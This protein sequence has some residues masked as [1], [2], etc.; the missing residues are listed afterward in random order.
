LAQ[1]ILPAHTPCVWDLV[2]A[3]AM[4]GTFL[5]W[6]VLCVVVR[7]NVASRAVECIS[8][9]VLCAVSTPHTERLVSYVA[10]ASE[11]TENMGAVFCHAVT[12]LVVVLPAWAHRR[13]RKVPTTAKGFPIICTEEDHPRASRS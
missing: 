13:A 1:L 9:F 10:R 5:C 7:G 6:A 3:F 8:S 2:L 12:V 4:Y 11:S